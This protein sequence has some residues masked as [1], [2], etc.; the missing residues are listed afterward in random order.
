MSCQCRR[1]FFVSDSDIK[2]VRLRFFDKTDV[3]PGAPDIWGWEVPGMYLTQ[4]PSI[5]LL[6]VQVPR[7]MFYLQIM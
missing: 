6:T 5:D 2:S 7:Y 4:V 3:P 1:M